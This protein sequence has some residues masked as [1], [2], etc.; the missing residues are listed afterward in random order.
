V[1]DR[2]APGR[3]GRRRRLTVQYLQPYSCILEEP[4]SGR[5]G[6]FWEFAE[7]PNVFPEG[8]TLTLAKGDLEQLHYLR[9]HTFTNVL[10]GF[11]LTTVDRYAPLLSLLCAFFVVHVPRIFAPHAPRN[12]PLIT[13]LDCRWQLFRDSWSFRPFMAQRRI[14]CADDQ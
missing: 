4:P 14:R 2:Q 8:N 10:L 6:L 9:L 11:L 12:R 7:W 3:S 1:S 13:Y 5:K